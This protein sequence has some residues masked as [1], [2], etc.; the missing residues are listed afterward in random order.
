M[1]FAFN[2]LGMLLL[3][4]PLLLN[5]PYLRLAKDWEEPEAVSETR[6]TL[7][8]IF[9]VLMMLAMVLIANTT[10]GSSL[11]LI[12]TLLSLVLY[13][14][15][16]R[17]IWKNPE[18]KELYVPLIFIPYPLAVFPVLYFVLCG[19]YLGN[20]PLIVLAFLFGGV[21]ITNTHTKAKKYKKG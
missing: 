21:H 11:L 4:L 13:A 1:Y 3:L 14:W 18:E 20:Y 8:G 2:W 5:V 19:F 7:E 15:C 16:W 6:E 10:R 12:P 17:R 9:R